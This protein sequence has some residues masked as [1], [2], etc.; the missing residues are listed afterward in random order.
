M[1][2]FYLFLIVY[3][4]PKSHIC[5]GIYT[6]LGK[7]IWEFYCLIYYW[8]LSRGMVWKG[9]PNEKKWDIQGVQECS[10]PKNAKV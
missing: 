6:K 1:K 3:F 5:L 4:V 8:D 2:L 9:N 7:T 10:I